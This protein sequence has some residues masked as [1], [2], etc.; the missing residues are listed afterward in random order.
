MIALT[1]RVESLDPGL[2]H[3]DK[4]IAL[5]GQLTLLRCRCE[6]DL[7][8]TVDALGRAEGLARELELAEAAL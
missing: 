2:P 7:P 6:Q 4:L 5:R 1:I 8:V 3:K